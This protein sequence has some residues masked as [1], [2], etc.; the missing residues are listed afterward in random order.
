[1]KKLTRKNPTDIYSLWLDL[2]S[3]DKSKARK[4]ALALRQQFAGKSTFSDF[5]PI[6]SNE[7]DLTVN[8]IKARIE[9]VIKKTSGARVNPIKKLIKRRNPVPNLV[10]LNETNLKK[11]GLELIG[12]KS[13]YSLDDL[14][15]IYKINSNKIKKGIYSF[16]VLTEFDRVLGNYGIESITK[17]KQLRESKGSVIYYSNSGETY[18]ATII[19]WKD[20]Y[21]IGNWGFIVE[22][23]HRS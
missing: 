19:W 15:E 12:N 21:W 8:E 3:K 1:M 14:L 4:A 16:L 7:R 22:E 9:S 6:I 23:G 11:Y 18:N 5:W 20:N 10:K 2:S 13:D 17:N